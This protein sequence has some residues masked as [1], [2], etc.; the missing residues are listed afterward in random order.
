MD[1]SG[2]VPY[3]W[4]SAFSASTDHLIVTNRLGIDTGHRA[5][6]FDLTSGEVVAKIAGQSEAYGVTV[7]P[8]GTYFLLTGNDASATV[9]TADG[10]AIRELPLATPPGY[11][12]GWSPTARLSPWRLQRSIPLWATDTWEMVANFGHKG[13]PTSLLFS[14]Q[15]RTLNVVTSFGG[16]FVLDL[17]GP[18]GRPEADRLG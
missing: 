18:D 2:T 11:A 3:A 10:D 15:G 8:D 9:L 6:I 17:N 16:I 1:F 5:V 13:M 7:S 4:D 12:A 14:P